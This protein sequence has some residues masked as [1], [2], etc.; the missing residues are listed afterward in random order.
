MARKAQCQRDVQNNR[1]QWGGSDAG[2]VLPTPSVG[3][4]TSVYSS[5]LARLRREPRLG[6][7]H[8]GCGSELFN[9]GVWRE[10]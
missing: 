10:D 3:K 5:F 1:H 6:V 2:R 4:V 8:R 7:G 9:A